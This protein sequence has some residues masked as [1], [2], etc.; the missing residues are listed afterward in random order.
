M[1]NPAGRSPAGIF[2]MPSPGYIRRLSGRILVG[3]NRAPGNGV[4]RDAA[5]TSSPCDPGERAGIGIPARE[6]GGTLNINSSCPHHQLH[7]W[8][9]DDSDA[10]AAA[11]Q[12]DETEPVLSGI[13]IAIG[14]EKTSSMTMS[15]LKVAHGYL[16]DICYA[17]PQ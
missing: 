17:K 15:P 4:V 11:S 9:R 16:P 14:A 8:G 7:L 13:P 12:T 3:C 10:I 1:T 2:Y 6:F 5:L